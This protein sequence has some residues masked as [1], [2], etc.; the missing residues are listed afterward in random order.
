M[1]RRFVP[2][3]AC[4]SGGA[5]ASDRFCCFRWL[6]LVLEIMCC[7]ILSLALRHRWQ[8]GCCNPTQATRMPS[9]LT[10]TSH[11]G[12]SASSDA[13]RVALQAAALAAAQEPSTSERRG[14]RRAAAYD[15]NGAPTKALLGFCRGC[16][17]DPDA[18]FFKA[19][20]KVGAQRS[21]SMPPK[22]RFR[23]TAQPCWSRPRAF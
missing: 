3:C 22:R 7:A 23:H 12:G 5:T 11:E 6:Q 18:V 20:K 9:K 4:A 2:G 17:V 10:A 13:R 15:D 8:S 14:P 21:S 19:D 16:G 1:C